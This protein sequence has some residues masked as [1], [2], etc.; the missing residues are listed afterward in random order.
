MPQLALDVYY[1]YRLAIYEAWLNI[2]AEERYAEA[3]T[4][5]SAI[6]KLTSDPQARKILKSRHTEGLHK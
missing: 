5:W 1:N 6:D 2:G 3:P 4:I